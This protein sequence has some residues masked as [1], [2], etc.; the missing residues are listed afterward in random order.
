MHV[1]QSLFKGG[2][3]AF[4]KAGDKHNLSDRNTQ[5]PNRTLWMT[6]DV[7]FHERG[8]GMKSIL[9]VVLVAAL[10]LALLSVI[11]ESG[12]AAKDFPVPFPEVPRITKEALKPMLGDPNVIILDVRLLDQW[13]TAEVKIPGALYEDPGDVD[14]WIVKYPKDKTL[15]F[16]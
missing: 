6:H 10:G 4:Y 7:H 2:N 8:K 11:M 5:N 14:S 9:R 15:V 1:H 3:N 16:Y 12:E 13:K